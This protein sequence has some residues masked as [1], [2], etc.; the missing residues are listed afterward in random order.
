[1]D[2]RVQIRDRPNCLIIA[3]GA[4]AKEIV[5]LQNQ[6]GL[7]QDD[8]T[9]KCLPAG[10]HNTPAKIAPAIDKILQEQRD[11]FDTVLIGYGECGTGGALDEVL[12]RHDAKRL[13]HAHCYEFFA[14]SALFD[15]IIEEEIGSFF[16]TDYLVKNFDRLIITGLGLDRYPHLRDAYFSNYKNVVYLAQAENAP[17]K[18]KAEIAAERL[19]L[20]L[21]YKLV[22]Y[23]DLAGFVADLKP[24]D[25]DGHVSG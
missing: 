12:N 3:C 14:G 5:T 8:I 13:P 16:L 2:G 22:G 9:L 15:E 7:S 20:D 11:Q 21:V 17:L 4:L 24:D 1:M 19:G 23:G 6:L 25:G 10:Y 18:D